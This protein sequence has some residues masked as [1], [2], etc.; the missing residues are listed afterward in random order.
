MR[1]GQ[2]LFSVVRE[3]RQLPYFLGVADALGD[4]KSLI[5]KGNER[6]LKARLEDA[7][8]FW[9]QDLKIP[10]A[11][12]AARLGQV[13]FQEKLGTY[14]DKTERLIQ[15]VSHLCDKLDEKALKKDVVAAA[16]LSKVDLLTEM[17]RE[18]PSLQGRVGGLY[19][20]VE[21]YPQT[22][23]RAVYEHY[24]PISLEDSVPASLAG[25][26][27]SL[28]DKLDSIVGVVGIGVAIS[29]SSDPF[30]LRRNA[31]GACKII[32]DGKLDFSFGRLVE[33]AIAAYGG[34]LEREAEEVAASCSAFFEQRLR[35]IYETQGYRYDLINAAMGAGL[36]NIYHSFLRLRAL[37]ALKKSP[38]FEPL[39]LMAKRVNNILRGLPNYELNADLFAEKEERE[40]HSTL[41]IVRE[42]IR[43]LLAKGEFLSAQSLIFKLEAP[44][45]VFFD[46]VLVMAEDKQVRQNRL[47]LLQEIREVLSR[48]ADYSRVVV[49]GERA[50]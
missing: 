3:G 7:R 29:G 44:L 32:L 36:D 5:R 6:V 11:R 12:R 23:W 38:Q 33:K 22:V 50:A 19:A 46:R 9:E 35:F 42:N 48:V 14:A 47:A 15:I 2:K 25:A 49:E 20:A 4:P 41:S 13:V 16:E 27:L 28:A 31:H 40:L 34:I 26:L 10:L 17:V 21:G 18:F 8:F 43:P 39:I 24:Q 45:G 30:G 37:D 1:E